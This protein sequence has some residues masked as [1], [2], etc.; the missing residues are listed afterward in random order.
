MGLGETIKEMRK[1]RNMSKA[2]LARLI[3]VSPAYITMIENGKKKNPSMNI[4]N[5]IAKTLDVPLELI[6]ARS[7]INNIT[8]ELH[9]TVKELKSKVNSEN[10]NKEYVEEMIEDVINNDISFI[11]LIYNRL[12]PNNRE[13]IIDNISPS[14]ASNIINS[15]KDTLEFE[16]YKIKNNK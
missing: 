1:E 3:E 7:Q 8:K 12:F 4:L 11:R 9:D 13:N 16:L 10:F 6:I 5:K 15:L 2:E 14:K